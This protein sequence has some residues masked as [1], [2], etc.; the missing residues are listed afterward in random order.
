LPDRSDEKAI[1]RP[2]GDHAGADPEEV[3]LMAMTSEPSAFIEK[4]F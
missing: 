4:I 2:S 1:F 3:S